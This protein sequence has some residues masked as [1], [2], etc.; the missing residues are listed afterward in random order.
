MG[1]L[2]QPWANVQRR[3]PASRPGGE[4]NSDIIIGSFISVHFP[5]LYISTLFG[6]NLDQLMIYYY[7]AEAPSSMCSSCC[8]TPALLSSCSSSCSTDGSGGE[9]DSSYDRTANA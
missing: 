2:L 1:V 8:S 6:F 4:N 9:T 3:M 5:L 7:L